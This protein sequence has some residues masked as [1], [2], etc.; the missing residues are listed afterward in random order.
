MFQMRHMFI[1]ILTGCVGQHHLSLIIKPVFLQQGCCI[2]W[3]GTQELQGYWMC[4]TSP[5]CLTEVRM[6]VVNY[7]VRG[8]AA[9][10]CWEVLSI[11]P[12]CC[13]ATQSGIGNLSLWCWERTIGICLGVEKNVFLTTQPGEMHNGLIEDSAQGFLCSFKTYFLLWEKEKLPR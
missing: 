12:D 3:L 5:T 1:M 2:L 11:F 4:W 13:K 6:C 9:W 7:A 8:N 10:H